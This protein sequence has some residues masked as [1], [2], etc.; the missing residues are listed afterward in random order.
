MR[1]PFFTRRVL[2]VPVAMSIWSGFVKSVA[3]AVVATH[4]TAFSSTVKA[5]RREQDSITS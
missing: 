2:A 4:L 5:K 1:R 3:V